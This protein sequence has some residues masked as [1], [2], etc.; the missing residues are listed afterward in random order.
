MHCRRL[1]PLSVASSKCAWP[2]LLICCIACACKDSGRLIDVA[3][4]APN[5]Q[6]HQTKSSLG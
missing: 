5:R 3:L 2:P 6:T 4:R 1:G